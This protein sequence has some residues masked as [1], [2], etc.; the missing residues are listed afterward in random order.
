[1]VHVGLLDHVQGYFGVLEEVHNACSSPT[2]VAVAGARAYET[3]QALQ[4]KEEVPIVIDENSK[5][6]KPNETTAL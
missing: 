1:M 2:G 5:F 3:A 6:E 4:S